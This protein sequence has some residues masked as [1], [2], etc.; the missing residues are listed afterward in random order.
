MLLLRSRD[1]NTK[2]CD[3]GWNVCYSTHGI[4]PQD[5]V[6]NL[7]TSRPT[8]ALQT[9]WTLHPLDPMY[10]LFQSTLAMHSFIKSVVASQNIF[11]GSPGFSLVPKAMRPGYEATQKEFLRA[12]IS[13]R[14]QY[15]GN[16]VT[17]KISSWLL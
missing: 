7:C 13:F 4:S 2:L 11:L 1:K 16:A 8:Q 5:E 12:Y 6:R 17:T 15:F 3:C 14:L 10:M 9:Q